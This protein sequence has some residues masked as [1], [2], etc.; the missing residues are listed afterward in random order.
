[1]HHAFQFSKLCFTNSY[2]HSPPAIF[3]SR[4]VKIALNFRIYFSE[5]LRKR[6]LNVLEHTFGDAA[7]PFPMLRN[8]KVFLT[9][10]KIDLSSLF[11]V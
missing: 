11:V 3:R 1:M 6:L 2:I 8:K 7:N 9:I 10:R 4:H 5:N